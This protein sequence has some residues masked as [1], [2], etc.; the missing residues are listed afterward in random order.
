MRPII[1]KMM[2]PY[3]RWPFAIQDENGIMWTR[4]KVK[5]WF[6]YYQFDD[7][8][9]GGYCY[10]SKH[11]SHPEFIGCKMIWTKPNTQLQSI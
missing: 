8:P 1:E 11:I 5:G 7:R 10:V 9:S 3:G 4:S 6:K 2:Q